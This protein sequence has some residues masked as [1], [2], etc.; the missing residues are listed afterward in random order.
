GAFMGGYHWS[1][2]V[3][4]P[5]LISVFMACAVLL[6]AIT[7]HFYL[8]FPRPKQFFVKHPWVVLLAIYGPPL[9]FLTMFLQGYLRV[10]WLDQGGSSGMWM[11]I[12][13]ALGQSAGDPSTGVRMLLLEML[14]EIYLYF[15]IAALWYL[16]SIASLVHSFRTAENSIQRNQVKW[17]L[18]GSAASLIPIGYTLYLAFWESGKFGGGAAT[19]PMFAASA[20][21]TLA[22]SFSITRYRLMALDQMISSGAVY[23]LVSFLAGLIYYGVVF[24]GLLLVG[25][26]VGEGPSFNHVLGVSIA[27]LVLM[28]GLDAGR[29]W[30]VRAVA[31]TLH[32][33]KYQL[34]RTLNRLTHA[35]DKLVDPS[36]L[37]RQLL[38]TTSELLAATSASVYLR[39]GDP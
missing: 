11:G 16:F 8:V 5:V 39:Q 28:V 38:S 2:I 14:Y 9:F 22:F 13:G 33:E 31:R 20:C 21:I 15:G 35:I 23:F 4:S 32:R 29:A 10:R 34:D 30:L 3:T 27:A 1:R 12:E 6:P 25:S 36:T 17:I 37:A 26:Q 19:W 18:I 24:S 7:L